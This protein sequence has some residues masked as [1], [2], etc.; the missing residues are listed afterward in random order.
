MRGW[1]IKAAFV[2]M[3]LI[4]VAAGCAPEEVAPPPVQPPPVEPPPV[5]P[6]P[7]QPPPEEPRE[8]VNLEFYATAAMR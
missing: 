2:A 8:I 7:V 1:V 3:G 6:P 4:L 5:Q